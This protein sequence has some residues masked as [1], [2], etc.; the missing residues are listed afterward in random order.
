[1]E[2]CPGAVS[3]VFYLRSDAIA[4]AAD[5]FQSAYEFEPTPGQRRGIKRFVDNANA[6]NDALVGM[7][8]PG[9]ERGYAQKWMDNNYGEETD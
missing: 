6:V 1:M 8:W 3:P 9:K 7:I 4:N 2:N 5:L